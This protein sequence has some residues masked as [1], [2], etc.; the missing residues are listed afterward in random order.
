MKLELRNVKSHMGMEDLCFRA[1]LY[2]DGVRRGEVINDG[3]GG[4]NY[5]TDNKVESELDQHGE[6][7]PP[8]K[9]YGQ[10]VHKKADWLVEEALNDYMQKKDE[11]K[12]YNLLKTATAFRLPKDKPGVYH[13]VNAIGQD[14]INYLNN[15]YGNMWELVVNYK[16]LLG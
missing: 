1:T 6:T 3:N 14:A 8:V 16:A 13:Y 12:F 2:I 4:P 5:Y 10:V 15:R 11:A 7:L 9:K